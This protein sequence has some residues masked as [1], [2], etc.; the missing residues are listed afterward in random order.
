MQFYSIKSMNAKKEELDKITKEIKNYLNQSE[1]ILTEER[2][3][4]KQS[5]RNI[6][7]SKE[8]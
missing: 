5:K 1:T 6:N 7:I 2:N 4:A 3:P 8:I